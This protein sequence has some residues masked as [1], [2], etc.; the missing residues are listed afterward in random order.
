ME[1]L[2]HKVAT[3]PY[4]ICREGFS[5]IVDFGSFEFSMR[6]RTIV[7]KTPGEP[8][9]LKSLDEDA[10]DLLCSKFIQRVALERDILAQVKLEKW[11]TD[12][13]I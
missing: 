1:I 2:L 5:D 12:N 10:Y 8:K 3:N 6:S 7:L 4:K 13:A 9:F 11:I